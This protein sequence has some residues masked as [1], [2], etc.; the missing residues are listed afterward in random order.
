MSGR[1]VNKDL[2]NKEGQVYNAWV[3]MDL[4]E[5]DK[6]GNYL[7][8][9]YHQNY[10][11]DLVKELAKHPIK[12]IANEQD[13]S[14]LIESLQRGNRQAVTFLKEGSEQRIF[15]EANPKFKSINIYDSNMQRFYV[16]Q[17]QNEKQGQGER[18]MSKQ[19]SKNENQKQG[20]ADDSDE[21]PKASNKRRK[22]QD[23]SIS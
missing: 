7:L 6:N 3:Q 23:N 20:A 18:N 16:K 9:H 4:K 12:E 14:R 15:I 22:K 8:K 11:F 17:G 1:A 13:K 21:M 5:T 10:G 2:I 19:A